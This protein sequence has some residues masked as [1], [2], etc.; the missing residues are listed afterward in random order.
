MLPLFH[1]MLS[2]VENANTVGSG[3][4]GHGAAFTKCLVV[5]TVNQRHAYK[6]ANTVV[7]ENYRLFGVRFVIPSAPSGIAYR[8]LWLW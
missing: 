6:A 5:A 8:H 4:G 3:N 7:Y 2:V 1:L